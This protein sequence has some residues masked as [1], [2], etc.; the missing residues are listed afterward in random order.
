VLVVDVPRQGEENCMP[1]FVVTK[2]E[3]ALDDDTVK[4]IRTRIR[5]DCSPRHVPNEIL[6]IEEVPR[7]LSGKV[8]EVPVKRILM[9]VPPQKAASVESLANPAALEYFVRLSRTLGADPAGASAA[10]CGTRAA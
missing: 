3:A 10:R 8:L 4:A 1:L 2:D 5:E 9:G 7:T 6:Q